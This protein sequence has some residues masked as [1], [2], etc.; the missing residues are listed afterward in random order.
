M[1][2]FLIFLFLQVLVLSLAIDS[3]QAQQDVYHWRIGAY[4]GFMNYYGDLNQRLF[5]AHPLWQKKDRDFLSYGFSAERSLGAAWS[6]KLLYSQGRFRANDIRS[7]KDGQVLSNESN[8]KRALN[9]Q[10]DVQDI[11]LIFTYYFDNGKLWN[12]KAFIAPYV[13]LGLGLTDFKNFADLYGADNQRYYYW[14]DKTIRN[15]PEGNVNAQIIR[16]DGIFE[17]RLDGLKTEGKDYQTRVLSIPL[18]FG[19]KFR[20]SS[21]LNMNVEA[22][23]RYTTSDFLDDVSGKYLTAYTSELQQ[24][25]GNPS[26]TPEVN[27]G[28]L[29][30]KWNDIYAF[31]SVS[32]HYNFGAKKVTDFKAPKIFADNSNPEAFTINLL[33]KKQTIQ[34]LNPL[35]N[36]INIPKIYTQSLDKK[37]SSENKIKRQLIDNQVFTRPD[38]SVNKGENL[39]YNLLPDSQTVRSTTFYIPSLRETTYPNSKPEDEFSPQNKQKMLEEIEYL[40]IAV[41]RERLLNELK[42]LRAENAPKPNPNAKEVPSQLNPQSIY[43]QPI[44][45]NILA[46]TAK[47]RRPLTPEE[48]ALE[49]SK[50]NFLQEQL[51]I[52]KRNNETLRKNLQNP[53]DTLKKPLKTDS[54][55][56]QKLRADSLLIR[57]QIA[58]ILA[59][60]DSLAK[61]SIN[62]Q[63]NKLIAQ[64]LDNLAAELAAQK[65]QQ[66]AEKEAEN[67]AKVLREMQALHNQIETLQSQIAAMQN[68]PKVEVKEKVIEK[69]WRELVKYEVFYNSGSYQLDDF[70]QVKLNNFIQQFAT[71][72]ANY[73]FVLKGYTDQ[74]GNPDRN[75]ALSKLR[76]ERVQNALLSQGISFNAIQ[77]EY[78]GQNNYTPITNPNYLRRVEIVVMTY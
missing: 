51:N 55:K 33:E 78:F 60:R 11:S 27:R 64:K 50:R 32:I 29:Q 40:E 23:A 72:G 2:N 49:Q 24:L 67:Q 66:I 18:T 47:N 65:Q 26:G 34:T 21:R 30:T 57:Q 35:N 16:Q 39:R 69:N 74:T 59:R 31:T 68:Q 62:A 44:K 43:N 38:F 58:Q 13:A 54:L 25:A 5:P 1:R 12:N 52:L 6:A 28:N 3:A 56:Q 36:A 77:I 75:L 45:S 53:Q 15:L 41:K 46:D 7:Q 73:R 20:L 17:T 9:V 48:I 71:A 14:A 37:D 42:T 10:T 76:A 63:E 61:D 4:G 19:L 70:Q 8:F 22:T